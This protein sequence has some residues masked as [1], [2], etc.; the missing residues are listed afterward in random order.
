MPRDKHQSFGFHLM[1]HVYTGMLGCVVGLVVG[2]IMAL[3]TL[4]S[5]AL[6]II[7]ANVAIFGLIG[8]IG[9][10]AVIKHFFDLDNLWLWI[11]P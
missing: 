10:P 9:G 7:L 3:F 8:L 6:V 11:R 5:G 4:G 1:T 2:L